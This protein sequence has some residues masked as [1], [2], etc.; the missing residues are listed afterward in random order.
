MVIEVTKGT[1]K[2]V[3]NILDPGRYKFKII[4]AVKHVSNRGNECLKV[5]IEVEGIFLKDYPSIEPKKDW[6]LRNLL[7]AVGIRRSGRF[8]LNE[9][10]LKGKT[11]LV[12]IGVRRRAINEEGDFVNKGQE[13]EVLDDKNSIL[14][15]T[16]RGYVADSPENVMKG[17]PKEPPKESSKETVEKNNEGKK[18]IGGWN[19]I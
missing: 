1:D 7:H 18:F 6:R 13:P 17:V 11:G 16:I 5:T 2:P 10:E 19:D 14:V 12:D 3:S 9:E 8:M 15:N 4:D